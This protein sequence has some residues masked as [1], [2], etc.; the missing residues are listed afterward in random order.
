VDKEL[1]QELKRALLKWEQAGLDDEAA[2]VKARLAEFEKPAPPKEEPKEEEPE[3]VKRG[4][5][6]P[7]KEA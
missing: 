2:K 5:G 1:I 6:R 4:P 3:T 7:R